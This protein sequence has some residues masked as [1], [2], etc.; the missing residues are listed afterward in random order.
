MRGGGDTRCMTPGTWILIALAAA[1][2]AIAVSG[3]GRGAPGVRQF[4]DDLRWRR[5][6]PD[7]TRRGDLADARRER[8]EAAQVKDGGVA[9]LFE[10]GYR[11]EHAYVEP[12]AEPLVRVTRRAVE[13]LA[14][15][16]HR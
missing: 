4:L 13:T 16:T 8:V 10:I 15:L 7:P 2:V 9:D 6:E 1:V 14:G 3:I 11:P 12:S 5:R